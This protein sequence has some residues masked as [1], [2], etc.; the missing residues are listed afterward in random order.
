MCRLS[1][2][3]FLSLLSF[4]I[5]NDV[6]FSFLLFKKTFQ[7]SS[8][9]KWNI[10][11]ADLWQFSV[12]AVIISDF[13]KITFSSVFFFSSVSAFYLHTI[14]KRISLMKSIS[15]ALQSR[16]DLN[17]LWNLNRR[18]WPYLLHLCVCRSLC[19]FWMVSFVLKV[20]KPGNAKVKA[21]CKS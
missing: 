1:H 20:Q 7:A 19:A 8:W 14:N 12:T 16:I 21:L 17:S 18:V 13:W 5:P 3:A 6:L 2:C 9:L 11:L 15:M 10:L 4:K